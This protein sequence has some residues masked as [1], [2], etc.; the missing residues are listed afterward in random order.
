MVAP[1]IN[2]ALAR[3]FWC[4]E[5]I[6]THGKH[7]DDS[8]QVFGNPHFDATCLYI[9]WMGEVASAEPAPPDFR[10]TTELFQ[11]DWDMIQALPRPWRSPSDFND[12]FPMP[13]HL[14]H[15]VS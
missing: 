15:F 11:V 2:P 3:L 6:Q 9:A 5:H 8:N 4:C 7:L 12:V 1:S 14:R 13:V 10:F